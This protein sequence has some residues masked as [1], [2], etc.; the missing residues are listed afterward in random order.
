MAG[1]NVAISGIYL[2]KG[3]TFLGFQNVAVGKPAATTEALTAEAQVA[4]ARLP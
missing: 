4:L 1:Q 3:P 2:L